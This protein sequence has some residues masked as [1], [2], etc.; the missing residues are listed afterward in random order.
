M[1]TLKL[2]INNEVSHFAVGYA[3]LLNGTLYEPFIKKVQFDIFV[4][5]KQNK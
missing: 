2:I 1:C 4:I 5:D 3:V